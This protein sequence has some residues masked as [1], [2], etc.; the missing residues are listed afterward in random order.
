MR[1]HTV[2]DLQINFEYKDLVLD[3]EDIDSHSMDVG[4]YFQNRDQMMDFLMEK[5]VTL[6]INSY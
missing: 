3:S 6:S 5:K 2:E 4:K 1:V